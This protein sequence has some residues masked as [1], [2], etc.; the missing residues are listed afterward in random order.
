MDIS[1]GTV[2]AN[3]VATLLNG[4]AAF[5][6]LFIANVT[7]PG[8]MASTA[9]IAGVVLAGGKDLM[10]VVATFS[11]PLSAAVDAGFGTTVTGAGAFTVT[12]ND[13]TNGGRLTGVLTLTTQVTGAPL[14]GV[15]TL[16]TAVTTVDRN[17]VAAAAGTSLTVTMTPA[18]A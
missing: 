8:V 7:T 2:T 18:P 16:N 12:P 15:S 6:A 10:T 11:E 5:A 4:N 14:S 1:A 13:G 9:P 17:G 3:Q